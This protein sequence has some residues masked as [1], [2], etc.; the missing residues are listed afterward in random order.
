MQGFP[1]KENMDEVQDL[2]QEDKG[3]VREK[4]R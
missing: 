2:E 4:L 3:K 1:M